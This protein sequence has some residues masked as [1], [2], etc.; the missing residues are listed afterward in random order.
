MLGEV[1]RFEWRYQTRQAGFFVAV[2]A[3]LGLAFVFVGTGYG[4]D[5]VH[6]NSPYSVMQSMGLLSLF[7]IFAL[8]LFCANAALRDS[9]HKME[10]LVFATSIGKLTYLS[11]RFSGALLA[12]LT[13]FAVTAVGLMVAPHLL[14]VDP[15]RVGDTEVLRYAWALAVMVL[16]N[17]LFAASLLFAV[18]VLTRSALASY[19]GAVFL[20]ALYFVGSLLGNSPLMAGAAPQTAESLARSAL[21]DPFGL[22][23]FFAQTQYWTEAERN[24]RLLALDGPFLVNRVLWLG[25]SVCVLGFVYK[26]FAF[27]VAA[28]SKTGREVKEDSASASSTYRPVESQVSAWAALRSSVGL[29]SRYVLKSGA[30]LS[31]LALWLF[32][33]GMEVVAGTTRAEYGTRLFPTTG[34]LLPNLREVLSLIGTLTVV[35]FGA[36]LVWRER[37]VRMSALLDATPVGSAV[38]YL[39]K[40][41]VLALLLLV[42]AGTAVGLSILFQLSRGYTHVEPWLYLSLLYFTGLPLLLFA[43]AVLWLQTLSPNRYVGMFLALLLA[44]ALR[45]GARVGLEH[46]LLRYAGGPPVGYSDM[47]GF[48]AAAESFSAFMLYWS[49][50]AGL[51]GLVTCGLWQR[52]VSPPLRERLAALP[53]VWGRRG[54]VAAAVCLGIFAIT[55]AFIF[56]G[57]NVLNRYETRSQLD[58]WKADYEKAYQRYETLPQPGVVAVKC[59]VDLFPQERR[60]QV[61]GTYQLENRTAEP[62]QTVWVSVQ[63]DVSVASL[64]LADAKLRNHD[65]RFGMY[66][67]KLERPLIPGARTE[68]AFAL[69]VTR[70]GLDT[71]EPEASIVENGSFISN[72]EAFPIIGYRKGYELRDERERRKRGLPEVPAAEGDPENDLE[73]EASNSQRVW[74]TL[75]A[76]VSTSEDQL[77]VAPGVLRREWRDGGRRYFHYVMSRPMMNGFAFVSARYAVAK[78]KHGSID[79]EVYYH[80]AHGYNVARMLVAATRSLDVFSEQFGPYRHEQLRIVEVPSYWSFGAL[81]RSNTIYYP[82]YRGFVAD[83]RDTDGVDL[84]TR[85]IAHEVAHQW[86]GDQVDAAPGPGASTLIESLAKYSEQRVVQATYGEP[87]LRRVLAFDLDRYLRGRASEAAVEPPLTGVKDQSYLYYGKGAVVMNALSDLMGEAAVNRALRT[88]V[89]EHGFPNPRP[90][91]KDLVAAL[92]AEASEAHHALIDQWM[93]EV[94]L[95]DLKVESA[96]YEPL[97]DGRYRVTARIAAGKKARRG[98]EDVPLELDEELDVAVFSQGSDE[99]LY[100]AKHRFTGA[101]TEVSVIVKERPASIAVDPFLRRVELERTDNVLGLVTAPVPAR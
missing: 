76:T 89:K 8:G 15:E 13:V 81:A 14:T 42:L 29:E 67:F 84:V 51:L 79:V 55:G 17:L 86:W 22:S 95:Y 74:T 2:A 5:N 11:A 94:V 45:Q 43:V 99:P 82:E 83:V 58:D 41:V 32:V 64:T 56:H 52:G 97:E 16:P 20:Y 30:F 61:T 100:A 92:H 6:I 49:A 4:P 31:L 24:T 54:T 37:V 19:V 85:R 91:S 39:S 69:D 65:A 48:G 1:L 57:T 36:E 35:Y 33:V 26:V 73:L 10:E 60:Y 23:A 98:G 3:F 63:R 68:L 90:T 87:H 40:L 50:F 21:L 93:V 101:H 38:F 46:G 66:E 62:V 12:A 27:R 88:F 34:L 77:A 44:L 71:Q 9:E 70:Q 78:V 18:S 28:G 53:R 7:S 47:D 72:T 25:V 59:N 96:N 75:D 80:P